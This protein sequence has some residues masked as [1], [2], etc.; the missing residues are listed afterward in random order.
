MHHFNSY[1]CDISSAADEIN[2]DMSGFGEIF[3][4]LLQLHFSRRNVTYCK[5]GA[6]LCKYI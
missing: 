3:H 1:D 2:T 5:R 4:F 6:N